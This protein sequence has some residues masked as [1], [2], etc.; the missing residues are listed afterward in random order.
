ME[1]ENVLRKENQHT[2]KYLFKNTH[3]LPPNLFS[4]AIM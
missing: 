4:L 3:T 2:V 1:Y